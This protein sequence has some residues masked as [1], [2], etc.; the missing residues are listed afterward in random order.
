[1][2]LKQLLRPTVYLLF[3]LRKG[4]LAARLISQFNVPYNSLCRILCSLETI[5]EEDSRTKQ[6][7]VTE[8]SLENIKPK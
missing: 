7:H 5:V 8:T 2:A 3:V 4:M 6:L 1:M